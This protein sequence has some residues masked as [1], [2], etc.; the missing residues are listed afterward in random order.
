MPLAVSRE[1]RLKS[2]EES[3]KRNLIAKI[4]VLLIKAAKEWDEFELRSSTCHLVIISFMFNLL[5]FQ[6]D[7]LIANLDGRARM[8]FFLQFFSPAIAENLMRTWNSHFVRKLPPFLISL[9]FFLLKTCSHVSQNTTIDSENWLKVA[10][11]RMKLF[12]LLPVI[13]LEW[14]WK[15][16][17]SF[18]HTNSLLKLSLF[19]SPVGI[20]FFDFIYEKFMAWIHKFH[21]AIFTLLVVD[22]L[23]FTVSVCLSQQTMHIVA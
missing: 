15:L 10:E 8:R 17:N 5:I 20:Q 11:V 3:K 1:W 14:I 6:N 16:K 9:F 23:S 4:N 2:N 18:N 12:L 22:S 7:H 21:S 19:S 13:S